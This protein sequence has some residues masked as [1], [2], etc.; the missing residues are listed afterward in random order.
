MSVFGDISYAEV[1]TDGSCHEGDNA[2]LAR[3]G[4]GVF[5]GEG[6]PYNFAAALDGPVQTSYRAELKAVVHVLR[7][8]ISPTLIMCDCQSVVNTLN[9]ILDEKQ[10]PDK[11]RE[12]DLWEQIME[13]TDNLDHTQI[14]IQWMPGHL[15]DKTKAEKRK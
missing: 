3:A 8:V 6:S 14:G 12:N 10:L 1:F 4:W 7:Q 11:L 5:Y 15:D 9:R 13:L 2:H